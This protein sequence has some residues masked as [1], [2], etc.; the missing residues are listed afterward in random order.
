MLKV[1]SLETC[2]NIRSVDIVLATYQYI[3]PTHFLIKRFSLSSWGSSSIFRVLKI[4]HNSLIKLLLYQTLIADF[5]IYVDLSITIH[6]Y[7][8]KQSK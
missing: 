6:V 3:M 1:Q 4:L 5:F 8:A 2:R 7:L